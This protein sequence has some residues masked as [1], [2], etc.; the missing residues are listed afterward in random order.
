MQPAL[1]AA[2]IGVG[3]NLSPG[4]HHPQ[5]TFNKTA[6]FK[7]IQAVTATLKNA[8]NVSAKG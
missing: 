2:M 7:G 1:K 5:M 4:L 3:A 6:L 8:A